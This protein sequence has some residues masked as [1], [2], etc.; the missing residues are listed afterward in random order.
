MA[1]TLVQFNHSVVSNSLWPHGL[2]HARLTCPLPTPRACSNPCP[3]SQRCHPTISS[4]VVLFSSWLQSSP[5]SGSFPMSQFL[6]SDGQSVGASVS[7]TVLPM[8][9][10]DWFSLG[11]SGLISLLSKG[12]SRVFSNT[13]VQKHQFF[14]T[15]LSL[16]PTL[17]SKH[18]YWKLANYCLCFLKYCLGWSCFS[19]KEQASF[20]FMAAVTICS[21][22]GA[23]E[24]KVSHWFH[25]FPIY[26][27]WSDGTKCHYLSFLNVEF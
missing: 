10:Q 18:D 8:N 14:G 20:N 25:C 13:K 7:A 11:L 21:D 2:Q 23:Q 17:T 22:F 27:S 19:S 24:N 6:T 16:N 12:L 26:L 15:Q 1:G 4:S 9:I 5:A 3:L